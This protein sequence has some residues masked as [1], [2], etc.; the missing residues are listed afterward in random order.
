LADLDE[1][2]AARSFEKNEFRTP[3]GFVAADFLEPE[4]FGVEVHGAGQIGD[5]VAGV[6]E[7]GDHGQRNQ[8]DTYRPRSTGGSNPFVRGNCV[9]R[10]LPAFQPL[11]A[12]WQNYL[13]IID[14]SPA[15]S[16]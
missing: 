5:T 14:R 13:K 15:T 6:E 2:L 3:G 8:E 1:F 7:A 4:H 16:L 11:P 9:P 10:Q 12:G